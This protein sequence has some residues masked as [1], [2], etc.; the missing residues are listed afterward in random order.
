MTRPDAVRMLSAS[1]TDGR[2]TPNI[3][4]SSRSGGSLSPGLNSPARMEER[5]CSAIWAETF[6]GLIG[7][8][9]IV[10]PA[11][12]GVECNPPFIQYL[13][14]EGKWNLTGLNFPCWQAA[15]RSG[16]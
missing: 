3:S 13:R 14:Y 15:A 8:K 12:R 9:I 11:K 5:T 10:F 6:F 7:L 16:A 1:R 4:A 2:E